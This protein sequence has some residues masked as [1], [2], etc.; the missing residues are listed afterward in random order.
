MHILIIHPDL[1]LCSEYQQRM[2]RDMDQLHKFGGFKRKNLIAKD[3]VL[4]IS[5]IVTHCLD[6]MKDIS[7]IHLYATWRDT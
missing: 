2:K 3:Q 1:P 7:E 5:Y 6:Q 4:F